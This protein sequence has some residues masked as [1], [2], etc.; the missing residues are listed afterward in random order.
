MNLKNLP[1]WEQHHLCVNSIRKC[2]EEKPKG[3]FQGAVK[4]HRFG[5]MYELV[6]VD[7]IFEV[8]VKL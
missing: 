6:K 7:G 2:S 1:N 3:E 5:P 4:R 8:S